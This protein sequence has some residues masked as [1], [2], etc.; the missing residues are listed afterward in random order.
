[1]TGGAHN[2]TSD[3]CNPVQFAI[4]ASNTAGQD[5]SIIRLQQH[6]DCV[7]TK[8]T[9]PTR[10]CHC[11][12]AGIVLS[13]TGAGVGAGVVGA[14]VFFATIHR[15]LNLLASSVWC[16]IMACSV[17]SSRSCLSPCAG[18]AKGLISLKIEYNCL[19][20]ECTCLVDLLMNTPREKY[21]RVGNFSFLQ[22]MPARESYVPQI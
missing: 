2:T 21:T 8:R 3:F 4:G 17:S 16:H 19:P 5:S 6:R 1:M 7:F 15:D 13:C 11:V 14:G 18:R 9:K 20:R 10:V 22:A 12:R